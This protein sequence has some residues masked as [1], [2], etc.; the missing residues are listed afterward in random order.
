M[1]EDTPGDKR[2][3]GYVVPAGDSTDADRAELAWAVRAFAA[4]RLPGHMVPAAVVVL[5]TLPLSVN[6]K[7]DRRALPAPGHA[8]STGRGPATI[9]EEITCQA[10]AEILGLDRVS[11]DDNFFELGGHSLLAVTLA[12]RLRQHG[13]PISVRALFTAPTPAQLAT[14]AG[15]ETVAVPPR[16]VPAG[17]A[18]R[19]TPAM[20]PL[21]GWLDQV[22]IDRVTAAVPGGSRN[23]ADV[24]PLAPLQ[25]GMFFHAVSAVGQDPYI[26]PL[27]LRFVSRDRLAEFAA[28]LQ[29]VVDRH[30]VYRTSLAWE[31]LAE[32]VQVVWRRAVLPVTEVVVGPGRDPAQ[33]LA[34]VAGPRMDLGRAPLVD[35]HAAA[36]PGTGEWLALVRVHHLVMDNT[37]MDLMIGEVAAVLAGRA[38]ELPEPVPF[39][40]FVAQARVGVPRQEHEAYFAGLLGDVTEPSVAFGISDVHGD[41]TG[42]VRTDR[43][44][45]GVLG[46]RI[47]AV[48]RDRAVSPATVWHLVWARVLTV[49]SG[50]DDVVF[51]TVLLGR[52]GA[53]T[54]KVPGPFINTLPVRAGAG[55]VLAGEAL[56]AMQAQLAGLLAHEHAPLTLAQQASGVVSPAPL[57]T[58]LLNYRHTAQPGSGPGAGLDGIAALSGGER[59]NYPVTVSVNDAGSG[60]SVSVLAV[61]PV[62]GELVAGLVLAAAEGLA[63]VL[64]DAAG[65]ALRRVPMLAPAE[66]EQVIAGWNDT[67]RVVPAGTLADLFAA[68]VAEVPDAVAVVSGGT[69]LTYAGLDA[70]SS[71]LARLLIGRGAGPESVVAVVMGRSAGLLVGLLGVVKSGAAYLPVDPG[72]PAER[73]GFMLAD[74][75]PVCV[76]AD[77]ESAA[78]VLAGVADVPVVVPEDPGTRVALAGL[79]AG[80]VSDAD[81]RGR[82]VAGHPVYVIYTSGSTGVPKGVAVT[83]AGMAGFAVSEVERFAGV[84]GCRVLQFAAAGFDASVLELC[85]AVGAGGTLVLPPAGPVAGDQLAAV[86]AG[87]QV[88]HAL[89]SPSALATIA[90]GQVPGLGVLIVGGEACGP[91]LAARWAPGRVMVNAYGPTEVTVMAT[92]SGPLQAGAGTVPIGTPVVNTR[93]FVLDRWLDPMPAGVAGELYVAGAGLAR[94]YHRRA[95]LTGARFVAC[96]FESGERMYRTG[97]LA[98]WT[99][100]GQL[101][102]AG[103]A[104]DQVKIRGFRIEPGEVEAVLAAAPG[105][106]QAAVTVREDTPGDKRLAGYVVPGQD[107]VAGDPGELA[108]AVRA[109]ASGQLPEFMV[110]AT[111]TVL[112]QF[113]LNPN[114]KVDRRALPAPDGPAVGQGRG[115]ATAWEEILCGLFAD[116]LGLDRV[117][118]EDSFFELGGHS[119]LATRLVSRVRAVLGTEMPIRVLFE[120]PTAAGVAR[121]LGGA[122]PARAGLVARVRPA[123]VALSFAQRRL[124]FL[125]QL[126]GPSATYNIPV[127]LRLEG[128]LDRGALAAALGDVAGRHEVLRTVFG[129]A[130]GE[131]FQQVLD[132]AEAVPEL[133]ITQVDPGG[134]G[135]AVAAE[136]AAPFDLA[137]DVPWRVRLLAAGPGVHVL[138]V[139]VHHIAGDGW[140]AGPLARD[141]AAAYAAR[142]AGRAPGWVP[143]PVQYADY[144]LWQ[145]ELLGDEDDPGSVLAGQVEY[146]RRALA[147][148]P[149]ELALPVDRPRP[150]VATFRGRS[151]PVLVPAG[152]HRKLVVL[153]RAQGVTLFMVMHAAVAVL[154]SRLGAGQDIPAGSPVAGRTDEALNDLV[155]FFVNTLVL[156]TDVSG[157]PSFAEVLGR[158][159]E[160]A[161][162]AFDHQDVPFERL[163]EILAP[164]R[165]LARNPLFQ[166]MITVQN[167]T[168]PRLNLPGLNISAMLPAGQT[169]KFDLSVT[170]GEAFGADGVPAGMGGTLTVAA[171][172]FDPETAEAIS[173]RLTRVLTA[174]ADDPGIA[175]RR[176]PVLDAVERE[177]VI[178]GWNDTGRVVPA[179]TLAD[180]FAARAARTPDAVAVVS[181]GTHLTYAGLDAASSRLARLLIGRGAGPESLVGVVM[182]RSAGLVVALLAVVKSG[183]AYLPVDPGYP[184]ERVRFMLADAGPVA[185]VA[186]AGSAVLLDGSGVPVV[187]AEDPG[188]RAVLAGLPAGPVTDAERVVPLAGSHPVYVIYTSGST[189]VPKGVAGSHGSVVNRL[190]WMWREFPFAA[191]EVCGHTTAVG[192]GDAVWQV[193]GP[194]LGGVRMVVAGEEDLRDARRLA[195]LLAAQRVSRMVVVPS[196]LRVLVE[197]VAAGAARLGEVMTWTVSGEEFPAGLL[198]QFRRV[199]PQAVVLNLYGSTEVMADATGF[200]CGPGQV[201]AGRVPVGAPVANTRVFVLDRWLAP[202]PPGVAG[203]LYV[204]GAGL[205]R[206]YHRRAGLTGER[207]VACPFAPGQRMYRTGDLARWRPDGQVEY[208]GRA[209]DQVKIRGFR[210]ELGEVEAVL[211][212]APGIAQATVAVREDTPGGKR[213]AGYVVPADPGADPA[214][215]ATEVRA[216][217]ARRLPDYMVP[218]AVMV[219]EQFP[220]TVNGKIDRRAL[221]APPLAASIAGRGPATAREELLCML[222]AEVLG[223]EQVGPE[224]SFFDLGGHSLLAIKLANMVGE[225]FGVDLPVRVVFQAPTVAQLDKQLDLPFTGS[226]LGV[227]FPIRVHGDRPAIFCMHP[228]AGVSWNYTYLAPHLPSEYPIYGLQARGL[229]GAGE[230]PSSVRDMASDYIAQIR[231]VQESGPYHLLGWSFGGIVAHEVAVQLQAAGEEIASLIIMDVYPHADNQPATDGGSHR[232][233]SDHEGAPGILRQEQAVILDELSDKEKGILG[234]IMLNNATLIRSH[235]PGVFVGDVLLV[236][237]AGTL[238]KCDSPAARWAAYVNGEISTP[239]LSCEH[240]HMMDLDILPSL[241]ETISTWLE[242]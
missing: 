78:G 140:S 184:A 31:G 111:V 218:Y 129:V 106:A 44:V 222:F 201:V 128:E 221:P 199:L 17:G 123:R 97:D 22:Q 90:P 81:R 2:L 6:G 54:G 233:A 96:P 171:D 88:S 65:T 161:L 157:N 143:L 189:G 153:A 231:S 115:P 163:V 185:A 102:Y 122:G 100:G 52:M 12:E 93:V 166:V 19:I 154:L 237:S 74:A 64:E 95:G 68:R 20:L 28:A 179:G 200:A 112:E 60:F 107:N 63:G 47:R 41:G 59:T 168:P 133:V 145:R 216:H 103:R 192:F 43:L 69:H 62:D 7:I 173:S 56:A 186:D 194:L 170:V 11:P 206:G 130:D 202:V 210:V 198:E 86:I 136:A 132:A 144:A 55:Q 61:S 121:W 183:A 113:P 230:L 13:L 114:G 160:R 37:V 215:V 27:L 23:V 180:L 211:A 234:R 159:R 165:S 34:E 46:S 79:D 125:W 98:R 220:L 99:R 188:T 191:G 134:L 147:G 87:Q 203:E 141:L 58:T 76:L 94:G 213:L 174:V 208:L 48:A 175:L 80:P 3:A 82:L 217:T 205:A 193:F 214:V 176:V 51:G 150:A 142:R 148:A 190:A 91:E 195:G 109:Y 219:L 152:V 71:R 101:E 167:N 138:V 131:P 75:G 40:D 177:Q 151:V 187:V 104:D 207:F 15:Q 8:A 24:Y 25:E 39:R 5:E 235:E 227:L 158:V 137:V 181:G 240:M 9:A 239:V 196:L 21:A 238:A 241:A 50:R 228:R 236:V 229:D 108:A 116:V 212:A 67:G 83:H 139:V 77:P 225:A 14:Q 182:G 30:E 72:N 73:V 127:A 45:P 119:L 117:G 32:P 224:D 204:A 29:V 232:E 85:L 242:Q 105:I 209:D 53:F 156:R 1:R 164:E 10:F 146:W 124:W 57:F 4:G 18:E 33:V 149:A 92:T 226:G 162:E 36:E 89:I 223:V 70:A 126:E 118:P 49:V 110:P 26:R 38:G 155:G 66:R 42:T 16:L 172:L 120:E 178:E 169:S 197:A 35:V 135:E 84:A